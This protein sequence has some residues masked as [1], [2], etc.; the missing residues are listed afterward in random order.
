MFAAVGFVLVAGMRECRRAA[1]G[2]RIRQDTGV[3]I[4]ASLAQAAP[5]C[6]PDDYRDCAA[7][8]CGRSSGHSA[9]ACGLWT[10][11]A[12]LRRGSFALD[13]ALQLNPAVLAFTVSASLL[14]GIGAGFVPAWFTSGVDPNSVLKD[15]GNAWSRA[16]SRNRLMSGLVAGE[17]AL[18]V[19][20][21]AGAG[22]L[23][24]KL[25]PRDAPGYGAPR[26][27]CSY[28]RSSAARA[29]YASSPQSPGSIAIFWAASAI[30]LEWKRLPL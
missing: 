12:R 28:F 30:L 15:E 2:A 1:A 21:L 11:C 6:A 29:K 18:S 13:S 17:V 20:L 16:R 22:L 23:V 3:A 9:G 24:E 4:R 26:G 25:R 5:Y 27:A 19:L 7:E 8:P 10:Y 14:T